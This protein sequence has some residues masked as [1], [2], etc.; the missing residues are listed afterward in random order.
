MALGG[1]G[2]G[3][4]HHDGVGKIY[5]GSLLSRNEIHALNG[6]YWNVNFIYIL[7]NLLNL[8]IVSKSFYIVGKN[9]KSFFI[10]QLEMV[11]N[12]SAIS[13]FTPNEQIM[14]ILERFDLNRLARISTI[15]ID[16]DLISAIV[17][18]WRHEIHTFHLHVGEMTVT[19][20]DASCMWGLPINGYPVVGFAGD[21]W[22]EDVMQAFDHLEWA[23]FY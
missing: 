11:L 4:E 19:L 10:E 3:H 13:R 18:R 20:E 16:Q 6:T 14:P 21:N 17:E 23:S 8:Y 9:N 7:I 2:R 15:Q 12:T 22:E 1:R 5:R